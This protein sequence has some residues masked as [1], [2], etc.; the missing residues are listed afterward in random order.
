MYR[1]RLK[2]NSLYALQN[3]LNKNVFSAL[4]NCP[5]KRSGWR[6]SAGRLFQ[7]DGPATRNARSPNRMLVCWSTQVYSRLRRT[8]MAAASIGDQL[9]IIRQVTRS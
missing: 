9:A 2:A 1:Q 6:R 4:R 8:K 7:T 3:R 5:R